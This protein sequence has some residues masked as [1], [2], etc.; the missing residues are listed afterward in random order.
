M[1]VCVCG[2][3]G[4]GGVYRVSLSITTHHQLV[5]RESNPHPC[6]GLSSDSEGNI[7][8]VITVYSDTED[9]NSFSGGYDIYR[10]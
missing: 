2:G 6:S 5:Q 9:I 3:G 1:C 4:G 8:S 10:R 7:I